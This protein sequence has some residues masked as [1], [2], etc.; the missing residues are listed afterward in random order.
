MYKNRIELEIKTGRAWLEVKAPN[1]LEAIK[2]VF[3][4]WNRKHK[5]KFVEYTED[6]MILDDQQKYILNGIAKINDEIVAVSFGL[7]QATFINAILK[8]NA[9]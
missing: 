9:V 6:Y 1:K 7:H 8:N 2:Q 3:E 4:N 5:I